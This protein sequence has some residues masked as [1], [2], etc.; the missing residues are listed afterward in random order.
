MILRRLELDERRMEMDLES[1]KQMAEI[2]KQR[3][4]EIL[5]NLKS[6]RR[7][8]GKPVKC[9]IWS[10]DE[11]FRNFKSRLEHWD[12]IEKGKGKYL[13]LLEALQQ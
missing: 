5:N 13:L 9:P 3:T 10:K 6:D 1:R 11:S 4:D 7:N 12:N 2:E 8:D